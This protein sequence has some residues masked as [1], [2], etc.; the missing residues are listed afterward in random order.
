M[1]MMG[2]RVRAATSRSHDVYVHSVIQAPDGRRMS[3]SLG[4]GIDPLDEIEQHGADA[5]ALRPA[6]DVLH[7][8]RALLAEKV[9]QGQQLANKLW[10]ASRFVLLGVDGGRGARAPAADGRGPLDPLARS[11]APSS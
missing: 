7:A 1:M 3:K 6:G 11:S 10:N 5:A 9:E 8:G 4:T 2:L